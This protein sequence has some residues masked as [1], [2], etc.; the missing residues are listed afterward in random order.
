MKKYFIVLGLL[1]FCACSPVV[2]KVPAQADAERMTKTYP[3]ITVE[4]LNQGKMFFEK[5]CN[6]CHSLKKGVKASEQELNKVLPLM[7]KKAKIDDATRDL[8]LK[9]L[10][11]MNSQK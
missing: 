2:L 6:K 8:I 4:N 7:A 3:G 10:V 9:Y 1:T 5:N 11:T